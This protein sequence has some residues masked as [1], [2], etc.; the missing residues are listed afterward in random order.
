MLHFTWLY[1]TLPW[2]YSTKLDPTL[3]YHG[4]TPLYL[5]LH[6]STVALLHS[7]W[8]FKTLSWLYSTLFDSTLFYRSSTPLS[9]TVQ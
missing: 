9:L 6:Y 4:S 5:T 8:L 2:L 1:I 7:T 3:L